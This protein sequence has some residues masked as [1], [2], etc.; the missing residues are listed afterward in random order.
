MAPLQRAQQREHL[1]LNRD[2]ERRGGLV[3]QH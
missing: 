1:S 2:V 3:E